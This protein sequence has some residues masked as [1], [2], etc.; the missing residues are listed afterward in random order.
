MTRRL[1]PLALAGALALGAC[2]GAE[3][4]PQYPEYDEEPAAAAPVVEAEPEPEPEPEP[5]PPPAVRVVAGERTAI[6]G[7]APSLRITSPRRNQRIRRGDVMVRAQLRNWELGEAPGKH[8]HLILDN[9]PYIALRDLSEPLNLNEL[10]QEKLG[11]ELESGTHVIRMFPSRSQH[12]SVKEGA[13]FAMVVFSY[14]EPTDDFELDASAPMLTYSRPKGCYPA[15]ERV[16]LDFYLT[17]VEA[18]AADGFRV[19]YEIDDL[20]GEVTSWNPHWIENLQPGEHEIELTLLGADGEPVEG[21]FNHTERTITIAD[22]QCP[23][24]APPAAEDDDDADE[25]DE[26]DD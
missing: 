14:E 15:G 4:E 26:D 1:S 6:E 22:G 20:E 17:N 18:L 24:A 16:L 19:A 13:P 25:D 7:S 23:S 10:V 11:H 9:E 3:P 8:V 5:P 12:E 2:G 21:P